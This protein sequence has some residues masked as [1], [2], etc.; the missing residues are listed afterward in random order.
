MDFGCFFSGHSMHVV[1]EIIVKYFNSVCSV[2]VCVC[3][4]G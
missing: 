4:A 1:I 2:C 3:V